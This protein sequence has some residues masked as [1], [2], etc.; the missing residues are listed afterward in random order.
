MFK[1]KIKVCRVSDNAVVPNNAY[2]GDAGFDLFSTETVTIAPEE[3]V[4]VK[5][6]LIFEIPKGYGGFILPRSGISV[7]HKI[8]IPNA[9][10]LI[11]SGYRGQVLVALHNYSKEP[12]EVIEGD[13]IAQMVVSQ[14]LKP[15]FKE[16][17]P[18]RISKSERGAGGFGSSGKR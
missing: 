12:Y 15:K 10:G 2:Y 1:R 8:S 4:K 16:I 5:T 7:N 6:G 3:T 13:R 14:V 18:N 17:G 9:P 11:D